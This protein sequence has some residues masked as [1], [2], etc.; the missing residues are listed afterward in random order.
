MSTENSA[1]AAKGDIIRLEYNAWAVDSNEMIDTTKEESAKESGI[2]DEKFTYAPMPL[3]VGGGRIFEGLDEAL[4]G[5]EVG[6]ETEV[7]I[8]PEK[9]AGPRDPKLVEVHSVREFLK[10]DVEPHPGMEVTMHNKTGIITSVSAGRVKVDFNRRFAGQSLKYVFTIVEKIEGDEN[11]IKAMLEMDYGTSEGFVITKDE[12]VVKLVL[13]DVCKYDSKWTMAKYKVVA[14]LRELFG[15]VTVD[16][17][18]EYVK[19]DEPKVEV[20]VEE[21]APEELG[22]EE[23]KS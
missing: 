22:S 6:K 7:I 16:L 2:F 21:K 14:D 3:L 19:K 13:P 5:A 4:V 17:I 15:K 18:E 12:E 20:K 11:K 10:Q 1:Q 23:D 8:P 9:A